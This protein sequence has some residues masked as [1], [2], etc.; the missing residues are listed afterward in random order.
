[1][2]G[3]SSNSSPR[4]VAPTGL[5]STRVAKAA[6]GVFL[7]L[8]VAAAFADEAAYRATFPRVE[9][10]K[11]QAV[12]DDPGLYIYTRREMPR[13]YQNS[14]GFHDPRY[15]ISGDPQE[16]GKPEGGNW[17]NESPWR[18]PGGTDAAEK[19]SRTV[20]FMRLPPRDSGGRWP[21]VTW[22]EVQ[23]GHFGG[24]AELVTRWLFPVGTVFGEVLTMIGPDGYSHT[25]EVRLRERRETHW[26]AEVLR[27]FPTRADFEAR[28]ARDGAARIEPARLV[29][30]RFVDRG[31]ARPVF[32]VVAG[33][34][35]LPPLDAGYVSRLLDSTPF[36][37]VGGAAWATDGDVT[38]W[39][40]T[41]DRYSIVPPGYRGTMIGADFEACNRCHRTT[42]AHGTKFESRHVGKYGR[43]EG[44]DGVLSWH[45]AEPGSISGNGAVVPVQLRRS[46]IESGVVERFDPAKHPRDRY[47]LLKGQL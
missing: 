5:Q 36:R 39:A 34:D 17:N 20:K 33:V 38:A 37:E 11:W 46:F 21:V 3:Q 44:A 32:D 31:H 42:L 2:N 47:A 19:I 45:P 22:R 28:L 7:W 16:K 18:N 29:A 41:A 13:A 10:A 12:L 35:E 40:P 24:D 9:S 27:P 26:E 43:I 25:W 14:G 8:V 6:R 23:P 1:M 4:A 30:A 15:N